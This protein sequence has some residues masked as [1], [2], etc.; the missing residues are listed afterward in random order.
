M[1]QRGNVNYDSICVDLGLATMAPIK[2]L[3][4]VIRVDVHARTRRENGFPTPEEYADVLYPVEDRL[5]QSLQRTD[6]SATFVG[7]RTSGGVV[8]YLYYGSAPGDLAPTGILAR[9]FGKRQQADSRLESVQAYLA[10]LPG[11]R[12]NATL[13][14]DPGWQSFLTMLAPDEAEHQSISDNRLLDTLRDKGD[15][16]SV[17]RDIDHF[18]IC[19]TEQAQ[20]SLA[21][22]GRRLGFHVTTTTA[23]DGS[24]AVQLIRR[25]AP[26]DIAAVAGPIREAAKRLGATYDG[27]G[28]PLAG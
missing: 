1:R 14:S 21:E 16:T 26:D 17:P 5:L 13:S 27:W 10:Q 2:E 7:R 8:S 9:T 24:R 19:P 22:T 28:C 18:V 15:D 12:S 6:Q 3:P 11:Y 20:T 25:D 4:V 23:N